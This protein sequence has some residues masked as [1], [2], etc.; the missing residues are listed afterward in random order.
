[1]SRRGTIDRLVGRAF[2]RFPFLL[3]MW[4]RWAAVHEFAS[5]P[6]TPVEGTTGDMRVALITTAGVHL[7]I[8]KPFDMADR[9]GDPTFREIPWNVRAANLMITHNYYDHR[10]ADRDVNLVLPVERVIELARQGEIKSVARRHYSFMGH[11]LGEHVRTLVNE[12]A[13]EVRRRLEEDGVNAVIL[14][15]A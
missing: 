6:W 8:Q 12:T 1:M 9:R 4:A 5:S 2:S 13:P 7:K 14:T 15:P 11:I 3:R 10:D